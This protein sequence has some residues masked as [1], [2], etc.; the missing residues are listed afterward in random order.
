M[1]EASLD[2]ESNDMIVKECEYFQWRSR[3]NIPSNFY[4]LKINNANAEPVAFSDAMSHFGDHFVVEVVSE[5]YLET[6][7]IQLE[8]VFSSLDEQVLSYFGK[9]W[10]D[11]NFPKVVRRPTLQPVKQ[12]LEID[13]AAKS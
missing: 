3:F 1:F 5:S 9:G 8:S 10:D 4:K 6:Y 7:L 13:D 12:E 11:E 2:Q